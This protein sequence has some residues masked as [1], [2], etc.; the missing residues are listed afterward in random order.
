[1]SETAFNML[2]DILDLP[3]D[4]TKSKNSTGGWLGGDDMKAIEDT[5]DCSSYSAECQK[6][7]PPRIAKTFT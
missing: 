5:D 1:M 2:V 7:G 3:V 4:E 6:Q